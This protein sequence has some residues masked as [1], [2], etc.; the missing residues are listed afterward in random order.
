MSRVL[1]LGG[2]RNVGYLLTKRLVAEGHEVTHLHSQPRNCIGVRDIVGDRSSLPAADVA[3]DFTAYRGDDVRPVLRA[4]FGHYI[5]ISSGQV[6]LVREGLKPPFR[7]EDYDGPVMECPEADRSEWEYG[8]GKRECEDLLPA[9]ATRLRL[10]MV[11]GERD[12]YH[13]IESYLKTIVSGRPVTLPGGGPEICRH[14]YSGCV[15]DAI[16]KLVDDPKPGAFNLAQD[17]T[18]TLAELVTLLFDLVGVMPRIE[19]GAAP[20]PF[21]TRWM[22]YLDPSKAKRELGFR[23]LPLEDY[24]V[25]ILARSLKNIWLSLDRG[26]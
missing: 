5:F 13:R 14:V 16:A 6:Y 18:P 8:I 20:S 24:L 10:P 7:E 4:K 19:A 1:I 21:S 15:V 2:A 3:V 22:S 11:N 9:S 26:V 17:E 25:R 12:H 23:H